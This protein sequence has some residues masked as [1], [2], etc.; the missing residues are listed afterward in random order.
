MWPPLAF[1]SIDTRLGI[2]YISVWH[3]CFTSGSWN[4]M[5]MIASISLVFSVQ[6]WFLSL[7]LTILQRFSIGLRSG[8]FPGQ[9]RILI[10]LS[11]MNCLTFFEVWHGARSCWYRPSVLGG[12]CSSRTYRTACQTSR[13]EDVLGMFLHFRTWDSSAS[14]WDDEFW[15]IYRCAWAQGD[16]WTSKAL[17][18]WRRPV[19]ARSSA[20]SYFKES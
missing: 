13:Q 2:E 14:W 9:G 19:P 20:V 5:V 3:I 12:T 15:Q 17:S 11:I 6:S 1:R 18:E 10:P 4:H 7:V 16:A 8:E